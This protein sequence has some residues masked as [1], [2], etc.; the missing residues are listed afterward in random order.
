[1]LQRLEMRRWRGRRRGCS[2]ARR[3]RPASHS[4]CRTT[5]MRPACRALPRTATLI[6]CVA[7]TVD[8]PV[9]PA[10]IGAGDVEVAQRAYRRNHAQRRVA[11]HDL[12]HQLGGAIGRFRIERLGLGDRFGRLGRAVDGRGGREDEMRHLAFDGGRDQRPRLDRVVLVVAQRVG[13][14]FRHDDRTGE[15]DDRVDRVL[16]EDLPQ[17]AS[18]SAMSPS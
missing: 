18:R 15:M 9:P 14:R 11:Q 2:R 17:R 5:S 3:C 6:R 12:G 7:P 16:G 1:M 8:W 4:R 13:H 10:R